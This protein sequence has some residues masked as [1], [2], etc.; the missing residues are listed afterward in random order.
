MLSVEIKKL[1]FFQYNVFLFY[2]TGFC[3]EENNLVND[4]LFLIFRMD[5]EM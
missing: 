4:R 3:Y 2:C 5:R 1:E